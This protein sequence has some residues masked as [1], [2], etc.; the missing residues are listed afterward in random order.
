MTKRCSFRSKVRLGSDRLGPTWS[1]WWFQKF[2]ISSL[3]GEIIPFDE[4]IFQM[5]GKPPTKVMGLKATPRKIK[6]KTTWKST[7][8]WKGKWSKK[9]PPTHDLG[10]NMLFFGLAYIIPDIFIVFSWW[11][12]VHLKMEWKFPYRSCRRA[13][14][15]E[16]LYKLYIYIFI[17]RYRCLHVCVCVFEEERLW[18]LLDCCSYTLGCP[19]KGIT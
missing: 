10:F 19:R 12:F 13:L 14:K 2:V 17:Y 18:F 5:G 8:K 9:H 3:F 16:G 15:F 4:H 6:G 1:G 11:D 7:A